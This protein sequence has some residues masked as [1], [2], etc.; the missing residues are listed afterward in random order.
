MQVWGDPMEWPCPPATIRVTMYGSVCRGRD[1]TREVAQ[2][3]ERCSG[4]I[5]SDYE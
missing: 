4:I 5:F 3:I 2:H 1:H